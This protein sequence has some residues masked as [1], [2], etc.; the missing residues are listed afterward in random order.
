MRCL[1]D[2]PSWT[3]PVAFT[4]ILS[5]LVVQPLLLAIFA[6]DWLQ[7]W[8]AN[9]GMSNP[10]EFDKHQLINIGALYTAKRDDTLAALALRFRADI[11]GL[12]VSL[13]KVW[14][15]S[16]DSFFLFSFLTPN[17]QIWREP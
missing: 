7:I 4:L 9:I 17:C 14:R 2:M 12:L 13:V 8:S 15:P 11:R 16:P 5:H 1:T 10:Y 3:L 6:P